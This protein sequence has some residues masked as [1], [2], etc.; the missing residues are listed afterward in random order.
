M[1]RK[2]FALRKLLDVPEFVKEELRIEPR[3]R[4]EKNR[5]PERNGRDSSL[6]EKPSAYS[7]RNSSATISQLGELR[8]LLQ[9]LVR[10]I[11]SRADKLAP[12]LREIS[13]RSPPAS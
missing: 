1:E 4:S 6:P 9:D 5:F 13:Q 7:E 3:S 10:Q 2:T 8:P 12:Y 11:D